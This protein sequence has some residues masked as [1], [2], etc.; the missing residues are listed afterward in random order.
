L[1]FV[2]SHTIHHQAMIG[3]LLA[4]RGHT[5]PHRFGLAPSTPNRH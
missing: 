1:A 2:V 5:V 4:T 3:V